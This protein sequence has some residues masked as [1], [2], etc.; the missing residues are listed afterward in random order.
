MRTMSRST[1]SGLT[2]SSA[3]EASVLGM[4][5]WVV[6]SGSEKVDLVE[7]RLGG[8]K[9]AWYGYEKSGWNCTSKIVAVQYRALYSRITSS[10][11]WAW[12]GISR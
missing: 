10:S 12:K 4:L 9:S 7:V 3:E 6:S 2:I 11:S 5:G 8:L 1:S